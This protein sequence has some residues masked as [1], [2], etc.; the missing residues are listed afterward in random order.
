M[1]QSQEPT[2]L[3]CCCWYLYINVAVAIINMRLLGKC[4]CVKIV[5][6]T[7]LQIDEFFKKQIINN[8]EKSVIKI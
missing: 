5:R 1:A 8:I 7:D 4:Q 3:S 2:V 6:K